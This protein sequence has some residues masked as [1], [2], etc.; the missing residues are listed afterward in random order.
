MF[1]SLGQSASAE[2]N[3]HF[4]PTPPFLNLDQTPSLAE[5]IL[6]P[7]KTNTSLN[8]T[9]KDEDP[10]LFVLEKGVKG[11]QAAQRREEVK[12]EEIPVKSVN[13]YHVEIEDFSRCILEDK[14]PPLPPEL[15]LR[16]LKIALA[17]YQSA[18]E[19][20]PVIL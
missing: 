16:N 8:A 18:K 12:E 6:G 2:L 10:A 20:R 13:I 19:G 17:A 7:L 14:T 4:D 1:T 3:I 9:T 15:G 5:G 11:Y